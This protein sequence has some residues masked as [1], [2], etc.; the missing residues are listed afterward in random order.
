MSLK[1]QDIKETIDFH[2]NISYGTD[3]L[4]K[5]MK[6]ELKDDTNEYANKVADMYNDMWKTNEKLQNVLDKIYLALN[7]TKIE[8]QNGLRTLMLQL[9]KILPKESISNNSKLL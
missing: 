3:E 6:S 5:R 9:G 2:K 4:L 1:A 8:S 7:H